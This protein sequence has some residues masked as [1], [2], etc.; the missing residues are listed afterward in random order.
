[1]PDS[2][3]AIRAR[4]NVTAGSVRA[5]YLKAGVCPAY[6]ADVD[7]AVCLGPCHV[8]WYVSYDKYTGKRKFAMAN[9]TVVPYGGSFPD[10]RQA[11][12]WFITVQAADSS[13][14]TEFEL[15]IDAVSP[16]VPIP[17]VICNRFG[18]YDCSNEMWLV[19][20]DLF[21][22]AAACHPTSTPLVIAL[23]I[24]FIVGSLPL[25]RFRGS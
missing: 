22:S 10:L 9:T 7:G 2:D 12:E 20:A 13:S 23:L 15:S 3:R 21:A 6:P 1:M 19:P 14:P 11:G 4:L 5:V 24:S 16:P 17:E 8:Q 25:F 18:R